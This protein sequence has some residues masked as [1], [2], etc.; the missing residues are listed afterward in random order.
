LSFLPLA[1][2][3]L[4]QLEIVPKNQQGEPVPIERLHELTVPYNGRELKVWETVALY[5]AS[6]PEGPE[7]IPLVPEIYSGTAGRI[8]VVS[9]FPLLGWLVLGLAGVTALLV[10]GIRWI[11]RRRRR[12]TA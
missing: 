7:G 8:N 12:Q 1:G 5:A 3:M 6:L 4:P 9:T 11:L 10:W 2:E